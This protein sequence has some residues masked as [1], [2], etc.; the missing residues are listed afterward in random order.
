MRQL[1]YIVLYLRTTFLVKENCQDSL[2][3]TYSV[4]TK[5]NRNKLSLKLIN[6][7]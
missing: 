4:R 5:G 7:C 3:I 1:A 2:K 6:H